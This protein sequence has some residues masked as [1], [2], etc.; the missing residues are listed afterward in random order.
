MHGDLYD[1]MYD[2]FNYNSFRVFHRFQSRDE[3]SIVSQIEAEG[4]ENKE[5]RM[6]CANVLKEEENLKR[7]EKEALIDDLVIFLFRVYF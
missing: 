5:R 1:K 2:T 6:H 3:A 4:K 7:K